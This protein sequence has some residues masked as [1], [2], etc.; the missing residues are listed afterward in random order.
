MG[1]GL[2]E[3]ADIDITEII[4][5]KIPS[6]SPERAPVIYN[7][8]FESWSE[9]K[10][11]VGLNFEDPMEVSQGEIRDQLQA[12]ILVPQLFTSKATYEMLKADKLKL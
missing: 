1:R 8:T 9:M 12:K 5:L 11:Q 6:T 4:E 2:Q 10:L 7:P 3:L